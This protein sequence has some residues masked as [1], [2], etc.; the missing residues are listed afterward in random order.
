[1]KLGNMLCPEAY[2]LEILNGI[3]EVYGDLPEDGN[4]VEE[5]LI[6]AKRA[7]AKQI[8][9][10]PNRHE[11]DIIREYYSCPNCLNNELDDIF[12]NYCP[13]CGQKLDWKVDE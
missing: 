8:P 7:V 3:D 4:D 10:K 9:K 13:R 5:A 11:E 2:T 12:D 6:L 1:M